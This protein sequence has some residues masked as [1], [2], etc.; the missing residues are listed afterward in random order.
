VLEVLL[1]RLGLGLAPP[2]QAT[3]LRMAVP[4]EAEGTGRAEGLPASR[5]GYDAM[6]CDGFVTRLIY[7]RVL[8]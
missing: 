1:V 2:E 7:T 5:L 6:T 3:V 8:S 4:E